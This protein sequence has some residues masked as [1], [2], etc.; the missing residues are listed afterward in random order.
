MKKII[1]I[2]KI[3]LLITL[4]IIITLLFT[5]FCND[6]FAV[7]PVETMQSI[8]CTID[9]KEYIYEVWQNNE[10]TYIINIIITQDNELNIDTKEYV[11]FKDLFE[12]IEESVISCGG[13]CK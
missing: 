6:Y 3:I 7:Q 4:I 8:K 2:L 11:N 10:T 9:G 5:V 12:A 13:S 1:N